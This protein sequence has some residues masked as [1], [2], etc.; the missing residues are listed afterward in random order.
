MVALVSK[1][2]ILV[3]RSSETLV[4]DSRCHETN[5]FLVQ[6]THGE[7]SA[8]VR[9]LKQVVNEAAGEK[10]TGGVAVLTHPTPSCRNSSFSG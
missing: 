5:I 3:R 1:S 4:W 7:T 2:N 6:A 10:N 9:L 8:M